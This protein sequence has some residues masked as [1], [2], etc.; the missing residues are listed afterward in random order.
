MTDLT[1]DIATG[2]IEFA[3]CAPKVRVIALSGRQGSGK[4]TALDVLREVGKRKNVEVVHMSFAQPL[5]RAMASMLQSAPDV[6]LHEALYGPSHLRETEVVLG[7]TRFTIRHALQ[8]LGTEWGRKHLGPNVWVDLVLEEAARVTRANPCAVVV[9]TDAR[10]GNEFRCIQAVGGKVWLIDRPEPEEP[11]R[12]RSVL[13]WLRRHRSERSFYWPGEA[14]SYA[15]VVVHNGA[16]L[17]AFKQTIAR[18]G[19]THF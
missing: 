5:K 13:K 7:S 2:D 16:S 4:D 12:I 10:F 11:S 1:S 8:T 17:E 9:I 15:D 14:R 19:L 18:L 3:Q 6:R